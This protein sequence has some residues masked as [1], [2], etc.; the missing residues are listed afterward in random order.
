MIDLIGC[1]ARKACL[2]RQA[3]V[4][5]GGKRSNRQL[6]IKGKFVKIER[7][8]LQSCQEFTL[9]RNNPRCRAR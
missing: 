8:S 9:H 5:P 7:R 3:I 4:R 6:T 1:E 2:H